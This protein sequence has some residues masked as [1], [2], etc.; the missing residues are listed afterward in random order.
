MALIQTSGLISDITGRVGGSVFQRSKA[1]LTMRTQSGVINRATNLQGINRVYA[2]QIQQA[3]QS[4]TV[5]ERNLW[6]VY[7]VFKNKS[8]R[9]SVLTKLTGQSIFMQENTVRLIH[10]ATF[11]TFSPEI[12]ITPTLT[13]P[14]QTINITSWTVGVGTLSMATDYSIPDSS[15]FFIIY[16]SR[17]LLPS[18]ISNYNKKIIFVPVSSTGSS[19]GLGSLYI[20]RYSVLPV[21]G[22]YINSD[23]ALY[24]KDKNT[25]GGFSTQRIIVS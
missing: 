5:S 13:Q 17:P 8:S 19:Q 18:Q 16:L 24:D 25:F 23:I 14:P 2:Q 1:G 20:S 10:I 11:G 15:K 6:E 21:A 9:K 4:L 22:Q 7:A 12:L 3:W